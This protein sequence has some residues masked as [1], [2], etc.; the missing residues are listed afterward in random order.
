MPN[1]SFLPYALTL[2]VEN[3]DSTQLF[4]APM[5]QN[6]KS[7]RLFTTCPLDLRALANRPAL[8]RLTNLCLYR[9]PSESESEGA[10]FAESVHALV[11]S[12]SLAALQTLELNSPDLGDESCAAIVR[13]GIVERLRVLDLRGGAMSDQG[14]RRLASCPG[15]ARLQQLRLNGNLIT[16]VGLNTLRAAGVRLVGDLLPPSGPPQLDRP[17]TPIETVLPY[18]DQATDGDRRRFLSELMAHSGIATMCSQILA[19]PAAEGAPNDV[20][21]AFGPDG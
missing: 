8:G 12:P 3:L 6:L 14:A 1:L 20:V 17:R 5:S 11:T 21:E 18:W 13:S 2:S 10:S 9:F 15:I 7:L 4:S 19:S 16:E